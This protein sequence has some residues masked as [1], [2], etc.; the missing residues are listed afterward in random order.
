[1]DKSLKHEMIKLLERERKRLPKVVKGEEHAY[2]SFVLNDPEGEKLAAYC[3]VDMGAMIEKTDD[4][5]MYGV[6]FQDVNYRLSGKYTRVLEQLK[7]PTWVWIRTNW[8][9]VVVGLAAIV[10]SLA[11]FI[12]EII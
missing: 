1:M 7:C 3:L 11:D 2:F 4:V 5:D 9:G 8:F 6:R 12:G 10:S